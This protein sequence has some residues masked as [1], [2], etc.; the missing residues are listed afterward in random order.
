MTDLCDRVL[1]DFSLTIP[2][3]FFCQLTRG[4]GTNKPDIPTS[5]FSVF[6]SPRLF[7]AMAS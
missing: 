2:L 1:L 6:L 7:P 4:L 5:Q 3:E